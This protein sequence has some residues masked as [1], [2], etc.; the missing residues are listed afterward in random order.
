MSNDKQERF[1][2]HIRSC[3]LPKLAS[4][5]VMGSIVRW[6]DE[7]DIDDLASDWLD[8]NRP[9]VIDWEKLEHICSQRR[10]VYRMIGKKALGV[11]Q[12]FTG[13]SP[14][15]FVRFKM[16]TCKCCGRKMKVA[17]KP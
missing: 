2:Q 11:L 13:I 17:K 6:R 16:E 5:L 1:K 8:S 3:G 12:D 9:L 4:A 14:P 15:E 7:K 10:S